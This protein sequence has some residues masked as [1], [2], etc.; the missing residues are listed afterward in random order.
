[1]SLDN[2]E[3]ES[4]KSD[5]AAAT[6]VNKTTASST[7]QTGLILLYTVSLCLAPAEPLL[8]FSNHLQQHKRELLLELD[9]QKMPFF[10]AVYCLN[11]YATPPLSPPPLSHV[12]THCTTGMNTL[13]FVE[14]N[15]S[16][17]CHIRGKK[18]EQKSPKIVLSKQKNVVPQLKCTAT[19][20]SS[21]LQFI[22]YLF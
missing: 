18:T 10:I 1:M 8:I 12:P 6:S 4:A 5:T 17:V 15:Y 19:F 11:V 21:Q 22:C 20:L 3:E 13:D 2:Q 14:I 9:I 16:S 7:K